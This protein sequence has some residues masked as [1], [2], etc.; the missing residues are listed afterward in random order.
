MG[1]QHIFHANGANDPTP[2]KAQWVI[3]NLLQS[4]TLSDPS[5][6]SASAVAEC[7]RSD[8]YHQALKRIA[9]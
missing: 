7:F 4:G 9:P 8:L 1:S 2:E 3:G 6:I 5:A